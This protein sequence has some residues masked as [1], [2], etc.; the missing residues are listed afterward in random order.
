MK[1]KLTFGRSA[2][3]ALLI[4]SG[5]N[6][7]E[8]R[9]ATAHRHAQ[10]AAQ[11]QKS[12]DE[13]VERLAAQWMRAPPPAQN[14]LVASLAERAAKITAMTDAQRAAAQE[15][16][17][18][19]VRESIMPAFGR[20]RALLQHDNRLPNGRLGALCGSPGSRVRLV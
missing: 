15:G 8:A 19:L 13:F 5:W 4:V 9:D 7:A 14:V 6:I 10:A 16:A 11:E 12:F 20:V 17:A 1:L 3:T 18:K 2:I